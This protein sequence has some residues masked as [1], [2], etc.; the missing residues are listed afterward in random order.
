METEKLPSI[1]KLKNGQKLHSVWWVMKNRC[2]LKSSL[3]Y[4]NYG[5]KGI[6]VCEEWNNSFREFYKW[7]IQN[8]Y[9]DGLTIDRIDVNGDYCPENCRWV[10]QKIQ[11][12]NRSNNHLLTYKG[13]TLTVAQWNE[14]LNFPYGRLQ[15]RLT[16][17]WDVIRAIEQPIRRKTK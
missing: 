15:D 7:A 13:I 16:K 14:K 17:G 12:N 6:R 5:L 4:K 8:G 1:S 2:Y 9:K 3:K 11:Q 10:T